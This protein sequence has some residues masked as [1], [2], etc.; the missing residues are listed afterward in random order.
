[1]PAKELKTIA[2]GK[3]TLSKVRREGKKVALQKRAD[4]PDAKFRVLYADPAWSYND[5]ADAECRKS[6]SACAALRYRSRP[7]RVV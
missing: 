1:M 4:L 2:K 3:T 6:S 7:G 5:K